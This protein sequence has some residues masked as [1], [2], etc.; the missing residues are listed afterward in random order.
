MIKEIRPK[1]I[2]LHGAPAREEFVKIFNF[3]IEE[4]KFMN[5]NLGSINHNV[6]IYATKKHFAYTSYNQI[7]ELGRKIKENLK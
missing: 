5:V 1:I 6:K 4:E 3:F 2:I 7:S